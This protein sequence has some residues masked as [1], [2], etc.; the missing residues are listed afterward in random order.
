MTY[1]DVSNKEVE[2]LLI[3]A[4]KSSLKSIEKLAG[5]WANSN[6]LLNINDGTQLVLKIWN[7]R[8]PKEVEKI[9]FSHMLVSRTQYSHTHPTH[10]R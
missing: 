10:T 2:E 9:S 7:E 8:T 4:G 6:Y 3:I 5:G 1:T